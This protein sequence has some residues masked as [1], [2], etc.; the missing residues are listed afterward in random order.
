MDYQAIYQQ[1][2]YSYP[3]K[4]AYDFTPKLD[5]S[6]YK[7][8]F[9]AKKMALY[10]HIPF[11]RTKCGYCNLFSITGGQDIYE[12]YLRAVKAHSRQMRTEIDFRP[13][14]F[15]TFILGGGTPL[16]L[17]AGQLEDLF[18]Y[19]QQ[20][21]GFGWQE[22]FSVIE[23]SPRQV[24]RDKLDLLQTYRW[25]RLSLGIQSFQDRELRMIDRAET[26]AHALKA[27]DLV[28]QY[29]IAS[30]NL[31]LIYGIPGQTRK[32]FAFSLDQAMD[33]EPEEV[34][35]YPLYKQAN[36]R[37][38]HKFD[39][40]YQNQYELYQFGRDYLLSRGYHQLS[41]RSFAKERLGQ[42][43]CGFANTL[44]LGCG[45]RSY[46]QD[47]HFCE[48]YVAGQAACQSNLDQY[49]QKSDFLTNISYFK[50]DGEEGK[51]HY[52]VKNLL[53]FTGLS[54]SDYYQRFKADLNQDFP[55][56]SDLMAKSYILLDRDRL[57]LTP[58]GM[59]LSDMIGPMFISDQ[60]RARMGL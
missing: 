41:M 42:K 32:T 29:E 15:D 59:G 57:Y 35:L 34:F 47:L 17:S 28:R 16:I 30:L 3:H 13:S 20:A 8:A 51:R 1:Y 27:L 38:Y 46:F 40:D 31:D 6:P 43:D 48:P 50:L 14:E 36:A 25:K 49:L 52:A 56:L 39:L 53:F 9:Q 5:I 7:E 33:F 22:V 54:L 45:G 21:Y 55:F 11:C 19:C 4:R 24:T 58:L 37:L 12:A 2:M 44:A 26:S 18:T 23:S 10:L 60:V